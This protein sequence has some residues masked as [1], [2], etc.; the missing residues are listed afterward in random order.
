M[1][2]CWRGSLRAFSNSPGNGLFEGGIHFDLGCHLGVEKCILKFAV[3]LTANFFTFYYEVV[4]SKILYLSQFMV[5]PDEIWYK[6]R[7][8]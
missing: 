8:T 5:D 4:K 6:S 3:I 7:T 2:I 1:G